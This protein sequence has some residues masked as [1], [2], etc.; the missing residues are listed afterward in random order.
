MR[1]PTCQ[2]AHIY[3]FCSF[4]MRC[5][6][7]HFPI[8]IWSQ[9]LG[10]GTIFEPFVWFFTQVGSIVKSIFDE[11]MG[12]VKKIPFLG[13]AIKSEEFI[14]H[15]LTYKGFPEEWNDFE[16]NYLAAAAE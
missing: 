4:C 15:W 7:C 12:A 10:T 13:D 2:R 6:I 8:A 1:C 5:H 16:K 9:N 14:K 11:V 3:H